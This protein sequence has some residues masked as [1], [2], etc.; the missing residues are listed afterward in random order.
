MEWISDRINLLKY[1]TKVEDMLKVKFKD[2]AYSLLYKGK[3]M[4]AKKVFELNNYLQYYNTYR[5]KYETSAL[6]A[7]IIFGAKLIKER[8]KVYTEDFNEA[9]LL[10]K[11]KETKTGFDYHLINK[12][13]GYLN[14]K[15]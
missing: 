2:R 5:V 9:Y 8:D 13:E 12:I 11:N 15:I 1:S 4:S 6:A 14:G 7:E 10:L 3:I